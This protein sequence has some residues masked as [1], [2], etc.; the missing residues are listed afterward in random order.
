MRRDDRRWC[1]A[2]GIF[3][4]PLGNAAAAPGGAA[5][6]L[7]T[8]RGFAGK[9]V[10]QS[11]PRTLAIA[12]TYDIGSKGSIVTEQFGRELSVFY[13]DGDALLMTHFCNTGNQPRLRLKPGTL[14]GVFEFDMFDITNLADKDAPHVQRAIY[15]VIEPGKITLDLVWQGRDTSAPESY[16]LTRKS[17]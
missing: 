14:P 4:A 17:P 9:W 15:H 7:D 12:M 1:F 10:I 11:G 16:T 5:A 8:F 2:I 6:A 13:L 3:L